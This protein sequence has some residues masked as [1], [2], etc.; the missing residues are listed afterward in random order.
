MSSTN[1]V[2][3]EICENPQ[4]GDFILAAFDAALPHLASTGSSGQWGS[5]PFSERSGS[6]KRVHD[7]VAASEAFRLGREG[8]AAM[9]L[10]I[11]EVE[12]HDDSDLDLAG[13][14]VR[15]DAHG[16][17]FLS[18]AAATVRE[19]WWPGYIEKFEE[20]KPIVDEANA[21]GASFYLEAL[22]SDFRTGKAR[23]GAGRAL[24]QAIRDYSISRGAKEL[25]LD[26]WAGNSGNLVKFY[27]ANGF[28]PVADFLGKQDNKED[29]PGKLLRLQLG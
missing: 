29:W 26:C 12:I 16:K 17:R 7:W 15:R 1:F 8:S 4:D 10:F 13:L 5:Q 24:M 28:T 9:R 2:I 6:H 19:H 18:V 21:R 22:I 23:K 27:V 14:S 20:L 11:A 3:R 25:F